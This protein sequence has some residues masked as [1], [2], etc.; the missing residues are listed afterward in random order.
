MFF[1]S[2]DDPF[3]TD[4]IKHAYFIAGVAKFKMDI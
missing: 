3:F 1:G 2:E 4:G